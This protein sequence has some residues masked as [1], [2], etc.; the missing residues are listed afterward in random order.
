[1]SKYAPHLCSAFRTY[2]WCLF[3]VCFFCSFVKKKKKNRQGKLCSRCKSMHRVHFQ[4]LSSVWLN[5]SF[6]L[7]RSWIFSPEKN[8]FEFFEK[9]HICC[10]GWYEWVFN[11]KVDAI[12]IKSFQKVKFLRG[13]KKKKCTVQIIKSR[14]INDYLHSYHFFMSTLTLS[15]A[16]RTQKQTKE[17]PKHCVLKYSPKI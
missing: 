15:R 17:S 11:E 2:L 5:V 14:M 1:M 8:C 10:D 16:V 13:S 6:G 4:R 7:S 12:R 9:G 3:F